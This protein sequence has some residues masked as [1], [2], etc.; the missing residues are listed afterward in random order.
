MLGVFAEFE[1][2][3]RR[4]R[5]REGIAFAKTRGVYKG[6]KASFDAAGVRRPRHDM[7]GRYAFIL[8]DQIA[9][10]ELRPL[11]NPKDVDGES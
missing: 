1:T 6:R 3:P 10:R 5:Q 7:L 4:E 8:P 2:N 11:R 9:R